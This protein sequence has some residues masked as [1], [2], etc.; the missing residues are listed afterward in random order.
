M[1]YGYF[2][3]GNSPLSLLPEFKGGEK[4]DISEKTRRTASSFGTIPTCENP[5]VSRP[6]NDHVSPWREATRSRCRLVLLFPLFLANKYAEF[7]QDATGSSRWGRK[8]CVHLSYYVVPC[9]IM[10]KFLAHSAISASQ[11]SEERYTKHQR[12]LQ[13]AA[14][15]LQRSVSRE[16]QRTTERT[17]SCPANENVY[18][19]SGLDFHLLGGS[20]C[21]GMVQ[22][23][24][25]RGNRSELLTVSQMMYLVALYCTAVICESLSGAWYQFSRIDSVQDLVAVEAKYRKHCNLQ[26][27]SSGTR[28]GETDKLARNDERQFFIDNLFTLTE[29]FSKS[30]ST[31]RCSYSRNYMKEKL[32]SHYHNGVVITDLAGKSSVVN[33]KGTADQLLH[34]KWYSNSKS[35]STEARLQ[36]VKSS[37]EILKEDICSH[38]DL[39]H[40]SLLCSL[41]SVCTGIVIMLSNSL[42]K[43]LAV[44]AEVYRYEQ[45]V[46]DQK[47][48]GGH[49][50]ALFTQF[51]SDNANFNINTCDALEK[52]CGISNTSSAL[53]DEISTR[54]TAKSSLAMVLKSCDVTS[55]NLS[56][57]CK[58]VVDGGYLSHVL[59]WPRLSTFDQIWHHAIQC[60]GD[61]DNTIAAI[62]LQ[63]DTSCGVKVIATDTD[64][65]AMLTARAN[66]DTHIKVLHPSP[67]K[68]T[69]KIFSISAIQRGIGEIKNYILFC[70]AMAG[71]DTT[72]AFFGKGKKQAWNIIKSDVSIRSTVDVFIHSNADKRDIISSG[73]KFA[74]SLYKG[75]DNYATLDELRVHMYTRKIAKLTVSTAVSRPFIGPCCVGVEKCVCGT[76]VPAPEQFLNLIS[77][78]CKSDCSYICECVW[79]RLQCGICVPSAVERRALI[80]LSSTMALIERTSKSKGCV[81][82]IVDASVVSL[83]LGSE[84]A[85]RCTGIPILHVSSGAETRDVQKLR[86]AASKSFVLSEAGSDVGIRDTTELPQVKSSSH[87][88]ENLT[89]VIFPTSLPP[90]TSVIIRGLYWAR[91]E[92]GGE[93][94][95]GEEVARKIMRGLCWARPEEGGE[96][97]K[98]EEGKLAL[99]HSCTFSVHAA[100]AGNHRAAYEKLNIFRPLAS[101]Q[102]GTH[103]TRPV[104][105]AAPATH[106]VYTVQR[107]GGNTARLARRSDEA[108]GVRVGVALIAPSLLVLGRAAPSHC[109]YIDVYAYRESMTFIGCS[110]CILFRIIIFGRNLELY[111][112]RPSIRPPMTRLVGAPLVCVVGGHGFESQLQVSLPTHQNYSIFCIHSKAEDCLGLPYTAKSRRTRQQSGVTDQNIVG[113]PITNTT[114]KCY[115]QK[116]NPVFEHSVWQVRSWNALSTP[117]SLYGCVLHGILCKKFS[118]KVG[119]SR[120]FGT[121]FASCETCLTG[122]FSQH[123]AAIQTQGPVPRAPRSQS[124]NG[125]AHIKRTAIAISSLCCHLFR[126]QGGGVGGTGGNKSRKGITVLPDSLFCESG[127]RVSQDKSNLPTDLKMGM[128][129]EPGGSTSV[130]DS[131]TGSS[132]LPADSVTHVY[133]HTRPQERPRIKETRVL[134][135]CLVDKIQNDVTDNTL[136][137]LFYAQLYLR[138]QTIVYIPRANPR[139]R[140]P[141]HT[142]GCTTRLQRDSTRGYGPPGGPMSEF[143]FVYELP[144]ALSELQFWHA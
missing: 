91:P 71:S 101:E 51:C 100:G 122:E 32:K 109:R 21:A 10:E 40:S 117:H 31:N 49:S 137:L 62:A 97:H 74:M 26:F 82:A 39:G 12:E 63:Y 2:V 44:L 116:I 111:L 76:L 104:A 83:G 9:L 54:K 66:N 138:R 41:L 94:H 144:A 108:L 14:R 56:A 95:K 92:E 19:K 73:E 25:V 60:S 13:S 16:R 113:T 128:K 61:T 132:L 27:F 85:K 33:F 98:G 5:G 106:L 11:R 135:H 15:I 4:R 30:S 90:D 46:L 72:S 75:R 28:D 47:N 140:K 80:M 17:E 96:W 112:P 86:A 133:T 81:D 88:A 68:T 134:S 87:F 50:A 125:Y 139:L 124:E 35:S 59:V 18:R 79:A 114:V 129:G 53:F 70:H 8:G 48:S 121:H 69:G 1:C 136:H 89:E 77:C 20:R 6:G 120:N 118:G 38:V 7:F 24:L 105:S 127:G 123:A 78:N 102:Q 141:V 29:S 3:P 103:Y 126:D 99:A 142:Q 37:V 131:T 115:W 45:S 67:G 119:I 52:L 65:L 55:E 23:S 58:A 34:D 84:R 110:C 130:S 22:C 64:V 93:S 43:Y 107:L 36:I 143:S 57:D 42:L